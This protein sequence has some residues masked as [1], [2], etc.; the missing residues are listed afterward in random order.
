VTRAD[1]SPSPGNPEGQSPTL[2][3][4]AVATAR[5]PVTEGVPVTVSTAE[6][7]ERIRKA[8]G[9]ERDAVLKVVDNNLEATQAVLARIRRE[10][11]DMKS[12][13]RARFNEI[14]DAVRKRES[15]LRQNLRD[16]RH[17]LPDATVAA[18]VQLADSYVNYAD[19]VRQIEATVRGAKPPLAAAGVD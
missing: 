4:D 8:D 11:L 19:A 10:G 17:A 13:G 9:D 5:E 7:A 1:V 14:Y 15:E 12:R 3:A 16:A 18:Q 2:A 6:T